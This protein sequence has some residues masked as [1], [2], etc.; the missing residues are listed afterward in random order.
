MSEEEQGLLIP[1]PGLLSSRPHR[2]SV[3]GVPVYLV[4][5]SL[6]SS[7]TLL[8]PVPTELS[9]PPLPMDSAGQSRDLLVQIIFVVPC[10]EYGLLPPE[11]GF[12]QVCGHLL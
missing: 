5:C 12:K 8:V 1:F 2:H 11:K 3:A 10:C 6:P 9:P 7:T 4:L